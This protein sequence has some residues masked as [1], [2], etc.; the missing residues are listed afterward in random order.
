MLPASDH[1]F[2][3]CDSI[4]HQIVEIIK[5][6]SKFYLNISF[7]RKRQPIKRVPRFCR[8]TKGLPLLRQPLEKFFQLFLYVSSRVVSFFSKEDF[9][10][11]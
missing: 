3:C 9:R 4:I 10:L 2:L 8:G 5:Y 1:L 6:I 7:D 11:S